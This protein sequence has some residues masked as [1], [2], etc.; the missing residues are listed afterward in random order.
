MGVWRFTQG[1]GLTHGGLKLQPVQ[2]RRQPL[3]AQR[4]GIGAICENDDEQHAVVVYR[5][6]T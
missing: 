2:V 3:L 5:A 6:S 1:T 4:G